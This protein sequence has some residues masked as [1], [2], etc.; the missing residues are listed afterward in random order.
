MHSIPSAR[1]STGQAAGMSV[2]PAVRQS[3]AVG[4]GLPCAQCKTYYWADLEACPVCKSSE[5]VAAIEAKKP[6]ASAMD[7]PLP[8]S[9]V[10]GFKAPSAS[11]E[12]SAQPSAFL[13]C[14]RE[15]HHERGFAPAAICQDCYEQGQEHALKLILDMDVKQVARIIYEA[16]WVDRRDP[17]KAA[18]N[19]AHALVSES[20][21]PAGATRSLTLLGALATI[22]YWLPLQ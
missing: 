21:K 3:K 12:K 5:R 22:A 15:E 4:Y 17:G 1:N 11:P 14:V 18:Q 9:V 20:R 13:P 7:Q 2:L 19:A 16:I 8:K 10:V 6:A